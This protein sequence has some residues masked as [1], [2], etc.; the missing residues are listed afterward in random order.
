MGKVMPST[1]TKKTSNIQTQLSI[2]RPDI[3]AVGT[4]IV[5]EFQLDTARF[6]NH[7]I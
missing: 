1:D 5:R 2:M 7:V 6:E 3:I 4:D